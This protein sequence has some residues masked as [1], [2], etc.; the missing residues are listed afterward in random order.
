M[1][2]L[3]MLA[4][5]TI[6]ESVSFKGFAWATAMPILMYLVLATSAHATNAKQVHHHGPAT[7]VLFFLIWLTFVV[8]S[9]SFIF[10]DAKV[11]NANELTED[12]LQFAFWR[13]LDHLKYA[14]SA[15]CISATLFLLYKNYKLCLPYI[16]ENL[17]GCKGVILDMQDGV[18]KVEFDPAI[19]EKVR[20]WQ[21]VVKRK[22]LVSSTGTLSVGDRIEVVGVDDS[23]KELSVVKSDSNPD[24]APTQAEMQG[25]T[26]R[27][28]HWLVLGVAFWLVPVPDGYVGTKL[29]LG[30][31]AMTNGLFVRQLG[32]KRSVPWNTQVFGF[33]FWSAIFFLVMIT[34]FAP[35]MFIE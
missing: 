29:L 23:L 10:L 30:A 19:T 14:L 33:L 31:V 6:T 4:I 34:L 17:V 3:F 27:W 7:H 13:N 5:Y 18:A 22:W 21:F 2:A 1:V 26:I 20:G 24:D 25:L 35:V 8:F 28:W 9:Q 11:N 32:K 12:S 15:L 16:K